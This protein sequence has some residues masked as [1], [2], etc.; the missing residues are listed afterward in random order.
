[1]G[2]EYLHGEGITHRDLKPANVVAYN[3]RDRIRVRLTDF[4]VSKYM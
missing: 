3:I 1:M 2:L 4:G